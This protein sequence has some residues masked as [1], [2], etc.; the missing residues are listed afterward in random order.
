MDW[1]AIVHN[2][3]LSEHSKWLSSGLRRKSIVSAKKKLFMKKSVKVVKLKPLELHIKVNDIP[4]VISKDTTFRELNRRI[5]IDDAQNARVTFRLL[6]STIR[7]SLGQHEILNLL[8]HLWSSD[9]K[10]YQ[11][12]IVYRLMFLGL[13]DNDT[14]FRF[15]VDV[16]PLCR[17]CTKYAETYEHMLFHCSFLNTWRPAELNSWRKLFLGKKNSLNFACA[18]ITSTWTKNFEKSKKFV[19]ELM[20]SYFL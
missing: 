7:Y 19:V 10:T 5:L 18:V 2:S 15:G 11:K 12:N 6:K 16:S 14:L 9:A 3:A 8:K 20:Y 17:F 4:Y 13:K 1:K